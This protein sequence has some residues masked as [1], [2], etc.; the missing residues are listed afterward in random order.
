MPTPVLA[1]KNLIADSAATLT[2]AGQDAAGT[3]VM[4]VPAA[5]GVVADEAAGDA[6]GETGDAPPHPGRTRPAMRGTTQA[7]DGPALARPRQPLA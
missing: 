4:G 7:T 3:D 5:A 6:A 2:R 1:L